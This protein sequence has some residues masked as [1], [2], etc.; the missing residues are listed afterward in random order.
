MTA[1]IEMIAAVMPVAARILTLAAD[2]AFLVKDIDIAGA[3]TAPTAT[4][5]CERVRFVV[6]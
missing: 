1:A 6:S 4:K 5:L 3:R 2:P